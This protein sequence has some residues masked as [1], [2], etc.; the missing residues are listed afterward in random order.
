MY[1]SRLSA[2]MNA[3]CICPS[4]A[5]VGMSSMAAR[6][7]WASRLSISSMSWRIFAR[8]CSS[9]SG[10]VRADRGGGARAWLGC[11]GRHWQGFGSRLD[12]HI[13][14]LGGVFRLSR[15]QVR[16][17]VVEVF[18]VPASTG[19]IDTAMMRMSRRLRSFTPTRRPARNVGKVCI[20]SSWQRTT[21]TTR[22]A[23]PRRIRTTR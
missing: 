1:L 10:C 18:G 4:V 13:A 5:V 21:G 7:V 17:V 3:W 2:S 8:W 15:D 11:P 23:G 12:A 22:L 19:S 16:Q 9:M 14:M 20:M 6:R